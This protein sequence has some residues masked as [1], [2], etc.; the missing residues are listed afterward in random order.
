MNACNL[1]RR[2]FLEHTSLGL[3]GIAL[4][5]LLGKSQALAGDKP[6][7]AFNGGLH[8]KAKVKRVIQLFMNGG[9][10][11]C[12]L[13]DYKPKLIEL[14]GKTFDPGNGERVEA[15][16]STPGAVMKSPFD[17]AQYGQSGR[18]VSSALPHTAKVVDDLAFFMAMS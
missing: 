18:W 15:S 14:H 4:A 16:I 17:W 12:D 10:S 9:A 1:T 8:H 13:F 5:A 2:D 6:N 11:Q 3:G 7:P